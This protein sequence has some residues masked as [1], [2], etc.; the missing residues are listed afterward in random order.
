MPQPR[1]RDSAEYLSRRPWYHSLS[2][3]AI[4]AGRS[5]VE[6]KRRKYN[7]DKMNINK[8]RLSVTNA[9]KGVVLIEIRNKF[10]LNAKSNVI[11]FGVWP[12]EVFQ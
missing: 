4:M 6:L 12:F 7:N 9:D 1:K 2:G 8:R 10:K 3:G 5:P 11:F